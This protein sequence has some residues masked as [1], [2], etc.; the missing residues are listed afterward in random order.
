MQH[1]WSS[2]QEHMHGYSYVHRYKLLHPQQSCYKDNLWYAN[3]YLAFCYLE[4]L[5]SNM[6]WH[7]NNH[8]ATHIVLQWYKIFMSLC[9]HVLMT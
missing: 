2:L 7:V 4:D 5:L 1:T 3:R 6:L 9:A 8:G